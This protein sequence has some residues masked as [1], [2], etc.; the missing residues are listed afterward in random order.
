MEIKINKRDVFTFSIVINMIDNAKIM[1]I[2]KDN[3]IVSDTID[4]YEYE[5]VQHDLI[6]CTV[7]KAYS[8]IKLLNDY[9]IK[10]K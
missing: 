8:V 4:Y 2:F 10:F 1:Q 3:N 9:K 7:I 6:M 5:K